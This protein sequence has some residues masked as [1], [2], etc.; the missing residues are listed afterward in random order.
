[1]SS[2]PIHKISIVVRCLPATNTKPTRISLQ[3]PRWNNK[4]K[5]IPYNHECSDLITGAVVW[6]AE[7]GIWP[8]TLL[9]LGDR[10][11]LGCLWTLE[12]RAAV[13]KAFGIKKASK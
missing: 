4:Q 7:Q 2:A 6:L 8:D 11:A 5:I 12:G 9:D 10:W 3:L 1:M 13:F